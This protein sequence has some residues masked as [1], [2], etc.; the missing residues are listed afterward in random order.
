MNQ[1]GQSTQGDYQHAE[2]QL[3]V[4]QQ[5]SPLSL[6]VSAPDTI[7][8]PSQ[9]LAPWHCTAILSINKDQIIG[10]GSCTSSKSSATKF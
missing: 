1:G 5:N 9:A 6:P 7:I 3:R 4:Q 2:I 10:P 8:L